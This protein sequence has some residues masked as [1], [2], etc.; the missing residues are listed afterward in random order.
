MIT[1]MRSKT[2]GLLTA[3]VFS[4]V[5][6][7]SL[8]SASQL[9]IS[10]PVGDTGQTINDVAGTATITFDLA[11]SDAAS[12]GNLWSA[13]A[14]TING[15][16]ATI[17]FDVSSIAVG[18][19]TEFVTATITFSNSDLGSGITGTITANGNGVNELDT[20]LSFTISITDTTAP[21]ITLVGDADVTVGV[22]TTYTDA[23]ATALDNVDGD[24]TSVIVVGGIPSSP[25]VAG[26]YTVTYDIQDG[27]SNTA[28]Q[29]TRTVNVIKFF[30]NEGNEAV[31]GA[32]NTSQLTLNVDIDNR[33]EGE[34]EEWLPLDTIEIEVELEN[35][36]NVDLDDVV[37][38]LG[39]FK[40]GSDTNLIDDMI[41]ISEDD[42][43]VEV[44]DVDEDEEERHVFKFRV[45]PSEFDEGD[46]ILKVKAY[47]DGKE[48]E[49]CIDF[50]SDLSDSDFGSSDFTANI[51]IDRESDDERMVIVDEEVFPTPI[52][53]FCS[54]EVEVLVDIYNIGDEDFEDQ[55]K[56]SLYNKALGIDLEEVLDGDLDEGEKRTVLFSFVIPA[57]ADE[58]QYKL[59]LRTFYDYDEDDDNYDVISEETFNAFL[60]VSG[61]CIFKADL[62]V[63]TKV[64]SGGKSGE[65]L[66]VKI[67]LT[68]T[69][70]KTVN[71][72]LNTAGYSTWADSADLSVTTISLTP[73]ESE[74]VLVT[75]DVKNN[76]FGNQNFNLEVL[77]GDK[78]AMTQPVSVFIEKSEG[79]F[80]K[81]TGSVVGG[82]KN[83]DNWY[84][85]IIGL[86][87]VV[88]VLSIIFVAVRMLRK[89]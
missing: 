62:S 6:F 48:D 45:D 79:F 51:R 8:A 65:N 50:S 34:D 43:E 77:S 16:S 33:G 19:S 2:F 11:N 54:E 86:V 84:L 9:T 20:P 46:Y 32:V 23:G 52:E 74:V 4:L 88:L 1:K 26:S 22:G 13:T 61:N 41:W 59:N 28:T 47:E 25:V 87:N 85:W 3:F 63:D 75:F 21:V 40:V 60:K 70:D 71:Y 7:V 83:N 49:T 36:K 44:G 81:I 66:V 30:C 31:N 82:F 73:G 17:S 39:L 37:F 89:S 78:L 12:T 67:T 24:L 29:V 72:V 27:A 76:A 53:A 80:S 15:G 35:N 64:E 56:V 58:K 38:E 55:I 57:D 10:N 14:A 5:L 42:E 69:G 18:P 68:N